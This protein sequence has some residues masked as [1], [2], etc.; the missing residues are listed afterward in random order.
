MNRHP[1]TTDPTGFD[2]MANRGREE[3]D[4]DTVGII[5]AVGVMAFLTLCQ[6]CGLY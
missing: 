2:Y 4:R 1:H 3:Q 5:L 6:Y